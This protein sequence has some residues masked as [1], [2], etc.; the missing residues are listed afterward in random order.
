MNR[1]SSEISRQLEC[2]YQRP[3]G[4]YLLD[5]ERRLVARA[6]EPAFGYHLLHLGATLEPTLGE[7]APLRHRIRA[8][9]WRSDHAGLMTLGDALPFPN[10]SIDAVLLHHA[11][12]FA[13]RPDQLLREVQRVLMP[14]GHLVIVGFNPWSAVG[15]GIRTRGL[16]SRA[17]WAQARPM[18]VHRLR[19]WLHLLGTEVESVSYT[20]SLPPVADGRLHRGLAGLDRFATRH[21]WPSGGAFVLHAQKQVSMLTPRR[22]RPERR[23]AAALIGLAV[24]KPVP[25]PREGDFST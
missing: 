11:M 9:R 13:E 25:S 19:D 14:R 12:E 4:Q 3:A 23:K 10:D 22:Q 5:Q 21:N 8:A 20:Y 15:A 24:P 7:Q 16:W 2:W 6:L 1:D 18:G 17:L